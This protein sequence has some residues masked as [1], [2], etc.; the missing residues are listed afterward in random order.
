MKK[1]FAGILVTLSILLIFAA[2]LNA[3][4]RPPVHD[5]ASALGNLAGM[6]F[7]LAFLFYS[8][9]WYIKLS[10]HTYKLAR[11]TWAAI[12]FCIRSSRPFVV[13]QP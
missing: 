3:A 5:L 10:G 2:S 8:V 7:D 4:H 13:S 12:L 6:L 11:Q 1:S 9:R